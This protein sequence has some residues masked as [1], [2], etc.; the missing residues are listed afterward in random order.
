MHLA[1]WA[2]DIIRSAAGVGDNRWWQEQTSRDWSKF[3]FSQSPFDDD[4]H[5]IS[6][7]CLSFVLG[8]GGWDG[9]HTRYPIRRCIIS[10][11]VDD[12]FHTSR[13]QRTDRP[14]CLIPFH[15]HLLLPGL[16]DQTTILCLCGRLHECHLRWRVS[17]QGSAMHW[18]LSKLIAFEL[19]FGSKRELN[20][21]ESRLKCEKAQLKICILL[22]QFVTTDV[23]VARRWALLLTSCPIRICI[24]RRSKCPSSFEE[25]QFWWWNSPSSFHCGRINGTAHGLW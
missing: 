21:R 16:F 17:T 24:M 23:E 9:L 7:E 3:T 15:Q 18:S 13:L 8:A 6:G 10:R 22:L 2:N 11:L 14:N 20:V 1:I 5:L 19:A 25:S 4:N 12:K